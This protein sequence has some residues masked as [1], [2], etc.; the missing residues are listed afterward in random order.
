MYRRWGCLLATLRH[1]ERGLESVFQLF[2]A[3]PPNQRMASVWPICLTTGSEPSTGDD[4]HENA[5]LAHEMMIERRANMRGHKA[6][7]GNAD[8][9]VN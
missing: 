9:A 4:A 2:L 7:D 5:I 1:A 6:G 3:T 8:Q